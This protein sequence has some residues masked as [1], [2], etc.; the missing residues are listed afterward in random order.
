MKDE[1]IFSHKLVLRRELICS[2]ETN[3]LEIHDTIENRGDMDSPAM[4]MYHM[5]LGY[6]LLSENAVLK[7]NSDEVLPRDPRAAEDLDTWNQMLPPQK[8]FAEQCYFH[9]F[10]QDGVASLYNPDV[11][12]GLAIHFD[13][14]NLTHFTQWKMMGERDYVLGLE[15]GNCHPNGRDKMREEG[16]LTTLKPGESVSYVV[17]VQMLDEI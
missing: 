16:T 13:P 17:K 11:K 2:L 6:P 12:V 15:P 7:V 9:K 14:K 3:E 8:Q 1:R 5:N 4:L 10:S